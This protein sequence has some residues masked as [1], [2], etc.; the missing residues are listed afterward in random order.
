MCGDDVALG[1]EI[2]VRGVISSHHCR[3]FRKPLF[4]EDFWEDVVKAS[5]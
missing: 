2:E 3:A 1:F 4:F 5:I